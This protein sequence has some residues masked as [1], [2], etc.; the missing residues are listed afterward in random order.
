[1][2]KNSNLAVMV[3]HEKISMQTPYIYI[4]SMYRFDKVFRQR[5]CWQ[6]TELPRQLNTYG[7][8]IF[9][10]GSSFWR[11]KYSARVS[12]NSYIPTNASITSIQFGC[13][14]K[15]SDINNR[16]NS[17]LSPIQSTP[18]TRPARTDI[19]YTALHRSADS[20][21]SFQSL[22]FSTGL[23]KASTN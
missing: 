22:G 1:M 9:E 15:I 19:F 3:P 11:W 21:H 18:H 16:R 5:Y 14:S 12:Q 4:F 6:R 2:R 23:C 7:P 8:A 10:E 13:N 20:V 17:L